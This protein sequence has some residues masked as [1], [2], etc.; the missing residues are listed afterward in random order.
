[1][2]FRSDSA[3]KHAFGKEYVMLK[4]C[5]HPDDLYSNGESHSDLNIVVMDCVLSRS[6]PIDMKKGNEHTVGGD[7]PVHPRAF[8]DLDSVNVAIATRDGNAF[9]CCPSGLEDSDDFYR[10]CVDI[11]PQQAGIFYCHRERRSALTGVPNSHVPMDINWLQLGHDCRGN[12][13]FGNGAYVA[14]LADSIRRSGS[15]LL[16]FH[17]AIMGLTPRSNMRSVHRTRQLTDEEVPALPP[18]HI[19]RE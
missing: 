8:D 16:P 4:H 12:I 2:L 9:N 5:K 10:A 7:A 1:M 13:S 3:L 11:L 15:N 6:G 18:N 19:V 14:R 17:N